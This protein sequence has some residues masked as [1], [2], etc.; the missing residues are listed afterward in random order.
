MDR[1]TLASPAKERKGLLLVSLQPISAM[2]WAPTV[3][4][5]SAST[6]APRWRICQYSYVNQFW[7]KRKISFFCQQNFKWYIRPK[8][9]SY[10]QGSPAKISF[11]W[12]TYLKHV[13]WRLKM[14]ST[15]WLTSVSSCSS[16]LF[17]I[18][19]TNRFFPLCCNACL[20][21]HRHLRNCF[22]ASLVTKPSKMLEDNLCS[23]A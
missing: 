23:E 9:L 3:K 5:L 4:G 1:S 11:F 20:L 10:L 6:T 2:E 22:S 12:Q 19:A 18:S 14:L 13:A 21:A 8:L 17:Y 7:G 16:N 15:I